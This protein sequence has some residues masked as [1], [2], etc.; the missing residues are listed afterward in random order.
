MDN[1]R[2]MSSQIISNE[3]SDY[4]SQSF[5]NLSQK[6]KSKRNQESKQASN[7]SGGYSNEDFIDDEDPSASNQPSNLPTEKRTENNSSP[8][9]IRDL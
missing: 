2:G 5:K 8:I 3:I 7:D 6:S 1:P 9:E 4:N